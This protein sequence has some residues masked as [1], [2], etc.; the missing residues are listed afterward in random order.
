MNTKKIHRTTARKYTMQITST[1]YKT[2]CERTF[3]SVKSAKAW[4]ERYL[5]IGSSKVEFRRVDEE[6]DGSYTLMVRRVWETASL[7]N[8]ERERGAIH[9]EAAQI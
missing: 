5:K 9:V 3:A 2:G 8:G 4:W 1:N 7:N 6:P